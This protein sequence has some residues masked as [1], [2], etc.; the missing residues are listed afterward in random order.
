[1]VDH[2]SEIGSGITRKRTRSRA[3]DD[4]AALADL[5]ASA[6]AMFN[7]DTYTADLRTDAESVVSQIEAMHGVRSWRPHEDLEWYYYEMIRQHDSARDHIARGNASGAACAA[8]RFQDAF[9]ELRFKRGWEA[10]A[11]YGQERKQTAAAGAAKTR[12]QSPEERNAE[13]ARLKGEGKSL[14]NSFK[15][16][17]RKFDVS[18]GTI[19]RDWYGEKKTSQS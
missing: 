4:D 17:A 13:V 6:A 8:M 10:F 1:M 14:R 16:A 2:L 11:M 15:I 19:E 7:F 12:K 18:V 5:T 3:I 9:A